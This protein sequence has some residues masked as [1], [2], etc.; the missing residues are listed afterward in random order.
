MSTNDGGW[1][2]VLDI[3]SSTC[4]NG[5]LDEFTQFNFTQGMFVNHASEW[6]MM[7]STPCVKKLL[8]VFV[9]EVVAVLV[10]FD[11]EKRQDPIFRPFGRMLDNS[12][13]FR[14][15]YYLHSRTS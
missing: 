11:N 14:I 4:E 13:P 2:K 6:I 9:L 15:V 7:D 12:F 8:M 10:L 1:K 3:D 5:F